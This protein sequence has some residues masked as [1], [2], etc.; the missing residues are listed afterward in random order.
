MAEITLT[1]KEVK[2][3]KVNFGDNSFEIPMQ[4]SLN[5]E[6]MLQ[7][8]DAIGTYNFLKEHIPAEIFNVLKVE[9]YNELVNL[10]TQES[11]KV[12]GK[13]TGES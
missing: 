2:T 13:T 5:W 7:I 4:G 6:E 3:L 12:S 10:W 8:Q 11:A 9:E 1:P